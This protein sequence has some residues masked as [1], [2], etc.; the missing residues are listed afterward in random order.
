MFKSIVLAVVVV[1]AAAPATTTLTQEERDKGIAELG[2]LKKDV[3]RR[4]KGTF[5]GPMELQVGTRPLV[6]GRMCRSYRTL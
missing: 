1:L 3:P 4:D 6:R 2:R 5:R